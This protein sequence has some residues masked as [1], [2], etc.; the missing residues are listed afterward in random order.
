MNQ[1]LIRN[2][3]IPLLIGLG[4]A[5]IALCMLGSYTTTR[6]LHRNPD[7]NRHDEAHGHQWLHHELNLTAQEAAAV[8]VFEPAYREQRTLLLTQFHGKIG[9]LRQLLQQSDAYNPEVEHA[10]HE[11][12]LIHG[13]LQELSIRHYFQMMSVLPPEKQA[14]LKR[15]AGEALS[16]PE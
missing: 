13:N 2:R 11:L 1:P 10:I 14:H 12:H 3:R 15:I 6:L 5:L 8:D 9:N 16:V 7:W 4:F